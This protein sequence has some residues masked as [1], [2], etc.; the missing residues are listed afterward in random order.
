[1][2]PA[3]GE[4]G[5]NAPRQGCLRRFFGPGTWLLPDLS[6]RAPP[7]PPPEFPTLPKHSFGRSAGSLMFMNGWET[8]KR[9]LRGREGGHR[10][11][12]GG[13]IRAHG[14]PEQHEVQQPSWGPGAK[15]LRLMTSG[16]PGGKWGRG[17]SQMCSRFL[18][19]P[20]PFRR[21]QDGPLGAPVGPSEDQL[22]RTRSRGPPLTHHDESE[23][24]SRE[25]GGKISDELFF[26]QSWPCQRA[27]ERLHARPPVTSPLVPQTKLIARR[28]V[29]GVS[30]GSRRRGSS[31]SSVFGRLR[32]SPVLGLATAFHGHAPA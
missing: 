1:M 6:P 8:Q 22:L 13:G 27:S 4:G 19:P 28:D 24:Q 9:R 2:R 30:G 20:R 18:P 12:R 15:P 5:R 23:I 7:S 25:G 26:L 14:H 16:D 31:P 32:A 29:S 11:R 10:G 17:R 21:A 3:S